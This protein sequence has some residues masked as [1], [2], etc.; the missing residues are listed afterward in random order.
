M[1][2]PDMGKWGQFLADLHVLSVEA[3]GARSVGRFL[4][5]HMNADEH[6]NQILQCMAEWLEDGPG[7]V[8]VIWEGTTWR[9]AKSVQAACL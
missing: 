4:T 9:R 8:E 7:T 3:H 6:S 5:P 2:R 1:V